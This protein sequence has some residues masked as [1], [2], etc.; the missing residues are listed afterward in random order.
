MEGSEWLLFELLL[1]S[2]CR[3]REVGLTTVQ[4]T[5]FSEPAVRAMSFFNIYAVKLI[6]LPRYFS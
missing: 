2:F 3:S 5:F 4:R 6:H 1:L